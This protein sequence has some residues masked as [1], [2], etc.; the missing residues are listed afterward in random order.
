MPVSTKKKPVGRPR[1][2]RKV[3]EARLVARCSA[4]EL[5]A[6]ER[7]AKLQGVSLSDFIR[8]AV[9]MNVYFWH[10]RRKVDAL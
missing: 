7:C 9:K 4:A 5:E 3:S 10:V 8:K 2:S 6:A 1:R